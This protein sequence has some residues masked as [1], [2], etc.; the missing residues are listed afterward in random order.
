MNK[1]IN[2]LISDLNLPCEVSAIKAREQFADELEKVFLGDSKS[3]LTL[4]KI[5]LAVIV[6]SAILILGSAYLI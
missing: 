1:S 4:T 6:I 5:C 3:N 2:E